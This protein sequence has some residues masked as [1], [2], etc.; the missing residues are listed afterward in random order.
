ML[1]T[2]KIVYD[3]PAAE[4]S[5][6]VEMQNQESPNFQPEDVEAEIPSVK[7]NE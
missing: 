4:D 2:R 1:K 6:N 5:V 3:S 7:I